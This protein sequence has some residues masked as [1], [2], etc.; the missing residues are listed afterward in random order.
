[1]KKEIQNATVNERGDLVCPYC[2]ANII[3]PDVM[4]LQEGMGQCDFCRESFWV[5]EEAAKLANERAI[6]RNTANPPTIPEWNTKPG[7]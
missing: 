5:T 4:V 3:T 2:K 6:A 1:M 7:F